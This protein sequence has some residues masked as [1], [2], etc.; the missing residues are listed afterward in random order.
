MILFRNCY[1]GDRIARRVLTY[2]LRVHG[3][4]L[5]DDGEGFVV[6][7]GK[8][9]QISHSGVVALGHPGVSRFPP[10]AVVFQGADP[11]CEVEVLLCVVLVLW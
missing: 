1:P 4:Q 8:V 7:V 3:S 11:E 2:A 5:F 6:C 10:G 9:V